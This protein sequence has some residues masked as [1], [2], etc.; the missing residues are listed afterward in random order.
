STLRIPYLFL[1]GSGTVD[2][3]IVVSSPSD[4]AAGQDAAQITVKLIDSNGVPVSG[5]TVSFTASSGAA[6]KNI[7]SRTNKN[8]IAS[9]EAFLGSQPGSYDF[10]ASAGGITSDLPPVIAMA[11]PAITASGVVDGAS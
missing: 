6:L 11:Q 10:T 2:N 3:L 7:Q 5:A 9:A 8:G 1:A 4:G